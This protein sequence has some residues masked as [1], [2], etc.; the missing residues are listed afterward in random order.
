MGE[1]NK[2]SVK[3]KRYG[4]SIINKL[5]TATTEKTEKSE[6]RAGRQAKLVSVKFS[7]S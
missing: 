3:V 5:P 4:N 7:Q 6:K 1:L 2:N